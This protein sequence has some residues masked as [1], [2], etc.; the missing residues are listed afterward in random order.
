MMTFSDGPDG[1]IIKPKLHAAYPVISGQDVFLP[2]DDTTEVAL[3]CE[4]R[5]VEPLTSQ[6]VTWGGLCDG[7]HGFDC[8]LT[9]KSKTDDTK[10][11]TCTVTNYENNDYTVFTSIILKVPG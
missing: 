8:K 6:M 1:V 4:A 11:V 3:V 5:N 9:F 10:E 2:P 7:Q